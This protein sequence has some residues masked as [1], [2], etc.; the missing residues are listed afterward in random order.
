MIS[1][2]RNIFRL[3]RIARTLARHDALFPLE[4]AGVAPGLVTVV[5]LMAL[6]KGSGRP[7]QRLAQALQELGPSFIKL[8]QAL[9]TRSDLFGDDVAADLSELQDNLPPFSGAEARATILAELDADVP[10]LF[11][12]FDDTPIAAASIAQ[13][14]M[15]VTIE[16]Q[17]VAV[18]VLRPGIEKAFERDLQLFRWIAR[19]VEQTRPDLRRLRPLEVIRTFEETVRMEMDLR[20]EAAA[21]EELAENFAGD[22]TF[23]VPGVDWRRTARRVLCLERVKG[24]PIDE[25][26]RLIEAGFDPDEI[27]KTAAAALF[28][29][30]FR[31]GYFHGDQHPGNLFV[32]AA[33]EIIAVDFGIMG[34]LDKPSRRYMGEML[35]SFL[36]R[37]Y[38]RVAEIHFEAGY[39]PA[40]KSVEAF[41]QAC[42]SIAEPILDKPQNEISIA[43]LLSQLF[44]VT[45][46]FEM[47]TQPQLLLLQKTMLVAEGVGR[48]LS[49]E[50]NMWFLAQPMIEDWTEKY[51]GVDARLAE[52]VDEVASGLRR[53]P[54]VISDI[55][56]SASAIAHR[57]L[58]I[59]S[60][61]MRH[62]SGRQ[63]GAPML[64]SRFYLVV[65]AI[66]VLTLLLIY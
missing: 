66:L 2:A 36:N 45:E 26:Q 58:K 40:E 30:V 41:A 53:L 20:M 65:I 6:K 46:T 37:D 35:M 39:V 49:P 10:E 64:S 22:T 18:K 3:F 23:R 4:E 55:E 38:R 14:H 12:S 34:R 62:M 51:M 59:D 25:R 29:Q 42:R 56:K 15:A 44:Q 8:G 57:G 9:S 13:V 11:S 27:L 61:Q 43:R 7:G 16:G 5:K 47:E 63:Q 24:I 50:A 48:I 19:L 28:K 1:S 32:G 21:A 17:N 31:D 33:G 60:G 54:R 52:V